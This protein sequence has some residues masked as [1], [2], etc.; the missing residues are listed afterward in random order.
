MVQF[1]GAILHINL[2]NNQKSIFMEST[3]TEEVV[4]PVTA[5]EEST[6]EEAHET[7]LSTEDVEETEETEEADET[8]DS[9]ELESEEAENATE[10]VDEE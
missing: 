1:A 3:F 5:T 4:T 7:V 6:H 9:E 10:E 8:E 2:T